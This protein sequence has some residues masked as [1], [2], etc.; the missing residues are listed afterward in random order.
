M[1]KETM[2][3]V[4]STCTF[5]FPYKDL[6]NLQTNLLYRTIRFQAFVIEE[7]IH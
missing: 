5:Q 2:K 4:V 7:K 3:I 6:V 1:R